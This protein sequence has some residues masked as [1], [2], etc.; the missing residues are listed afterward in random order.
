MRLNRMALLVV[1]AI[2]CA[3]L[4][5]GCGASDTDDGRGKAIRQGVGGRTVAAAETA[6]A[7]PT[8]PPPPA[9][10]SGA[11]AAKTKSGPHDPKAG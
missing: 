5:A 7:I 1:A 6:Q 9:D 10:S 2:G 8:T 11:G 3:L 4:T